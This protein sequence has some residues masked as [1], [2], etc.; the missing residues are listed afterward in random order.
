VSVALSDAISAV[1]RGDLA[2]GRALLLEIVARDPANISAWL[3][4]ARTYDDPGKRQECLQQV[5]ALDPDNDQAL[6]LLTQPD[7]ARL[8]RAVDSG[9][10]RSS[11]ALRLAV[12]GGLGALL[13][14]IGAFLPIVD[15]APFGPLSFWQIDRLMSQTYGALFVGMAVV[16]L[17]FVAV[18]RFTWL[19]LT[20]LASFVLLANAFA[21]L[22]VFQNSLTFSDIH[23]LGWL[24]LFPGAI[25]LMVAAARTSRRFA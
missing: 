12:E 2:A 3:W 18:R 13:L 5:L 11:K 8:G 16:S 1:E 4:L 10:S 15:V 14:L 22:F 17:L 6:E 25:L 24:V 21:Q 23:W 20:G 9:A 7:T 19:W